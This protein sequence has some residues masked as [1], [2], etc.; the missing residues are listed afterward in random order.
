MN[1]QQRETLH[2]YTAAAMAAGLT[3]DETEQLRRDAMR[4]SRWDE[5]ECNGTIQW[6]EEG[7]TDHRGRALKAGKPYTVTGQ[8]SPYAPPCGYW[9]QT[10]DRWTPAHE[11]VKALAQKIGATLE[12]NADPR[13]WPYVLRMADGSSFAPPVFN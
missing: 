5:H 4:V 7:Q 1:K 11:R 2:R 9:L 3:Y 8:S 13:G 6:A 10:A 12:Y